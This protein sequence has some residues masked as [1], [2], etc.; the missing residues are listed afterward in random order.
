MALTPTMHSVPI[1]NA[2]TATTHLLAMTV[3]TVS[4][5]FAGS[6]FDKFDCCQ[7]RPCLLCLHVC[8]MVKSCDSLRRSQYQGD[9]YCDDGNNNAG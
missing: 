2:S 9:G 5:A 1:V 4:K 7:F 3:S 6:A 8:V